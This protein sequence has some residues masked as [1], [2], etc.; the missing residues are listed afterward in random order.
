MEFNIKGISTWAWV[1]IGA[2]IAFM[3]AML[4]FKPNFNEYPNVVLGVSVAIGICILCELLN[5]FGVFG[6]ILNKK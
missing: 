5:M 1:K 3:A 4:I 2:V 6:K